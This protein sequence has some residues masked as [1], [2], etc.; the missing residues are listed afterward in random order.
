M[1]D[2][3]IAAKI[4]IIEKL[5]TELGKTR[6]ENEHYVSVIMEQKTKKADEM[7]EVQ[8]LNQEL[9]NAKASLAIEKERFESKQVEFEQMRESFTSMEQSMN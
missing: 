2:A 8:Q 7:D 6:D 5:T 4:E 9:I 1:Q 3:E